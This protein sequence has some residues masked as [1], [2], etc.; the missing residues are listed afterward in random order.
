MKNLPVKKHLPKIIRWSPIILG[1]G[2]VL[3]LSLFAFDVFEGE[4]SVKMLLGF[5]IHLLPSLALLAIVIASWKW[6]LVG[7]VCFL[8]FA[9]FYV[10]SVGLGRP[11]SWYAFI[12]GP[13]AIVAALF[14]ISWLQKKKSESKK[15]S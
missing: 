8:S 9:I 11:W 2:F 6:E 13:A 7:T 14:F 4:F 3:L 12:S 10:W 5:F 15:R 1:L